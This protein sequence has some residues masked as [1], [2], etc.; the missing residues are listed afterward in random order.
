MTEWTVEM[1]TRECLHAVFPQLLEEA[2]F[3][4]AGLVLDVSLADVVV[5]VAFGRHVEWYA[6][7]WWLI[8]DCA[9]AIDVLSREKNEKMKDTYLRQCIQWAPQTIRGDVDPDRGQISLLSPNLMSFTPRYDRLYVLRKGSGNKP[10][11]RS[12]LAVK[13][14]CLDRFESL[15]DVKS[16]PAWTSRRT[17]F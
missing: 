7:G 13:S 12:G 1:Q 11:R 3:G 4:V 5:A 6:R 16:C 15:D 8:M 14:S 2:V 17:L 10:P 9:I